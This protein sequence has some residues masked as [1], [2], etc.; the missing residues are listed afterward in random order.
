[1]RNRLLPLSLAGLLVLTAC[2]NTTADLTNGDPLSDPNM[3]DDTL[4][5]DDD[6]LM[7][8]SSSSSSSEEAVM[9]DEAASS[10]AAAAADTT[11]ARIIE[12]TADTWVFAPT[13]ITA[14]VG[15]KV[16]LRLTGV[17]GVHSF[18]VAELGINVPINP[19]ETK[20]IEIPT[21]KAGTFAFRCRIPCGDGHKD[22][23]GTLTIS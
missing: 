13:A 8:D 10:S 1:M 14:S 3:V 22:M 20:D 6:V 18:A 17:E 9:D 11:D 15:E 4:P 5:S 7:D 16:I 19:G 21:D 2:S 23:T 12:M